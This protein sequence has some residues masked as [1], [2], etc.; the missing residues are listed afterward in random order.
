[1]KLIYSL[2]LFSLITLNSCRGQDNSM[3]LNDMSSKLIKPSSDSTRIAKINKT[4]E[5]WQKE[6]SPI[7][8]RVMFEKG[9][10][11]PFT[12]EYYEHKEKGIYLCGACQL[13]LF[14]SHQK[15]DSFC[16]WPSFFSIYDEKNITYLTD[17][18]HGM[19]RTEVQCTRCGAHLGHVF[20]D[21]PKPTGL[22]YCINSVSLKFKPE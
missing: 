14:K 13:P 3:Q 17:S 7:Q 11:R 6:L 16:G 20:D 8:Y 21:G 5:E 1:M 12:G 4:K 15:F 10:E 2:I 22:R 18:T 9:T 19:V